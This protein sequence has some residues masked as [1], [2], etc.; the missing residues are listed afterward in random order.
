MLGHS[1]RSITSD[2]YTSVLPELAHAAAEA[3]AALIPLEPAVKIRNPKPGRTGT[4]KTSS[5]G[6]SPLRAVRSDDA[7]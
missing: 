4:R 1:A 5:S 7:A 3:A 6:R 2:T